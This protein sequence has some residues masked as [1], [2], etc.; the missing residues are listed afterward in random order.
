MCVLISNIDS[1]IIQTTAEKQELREL[2]E[3]NQTQITQLQE[4]IDRLEKLLT[5]RHERIDVLETSIQSLKETVSS[6]KSEKEE[7]QTQHD[8]CSQDVH[9]SFHSFRRSHQSIL[10]HILI[11]FFNAQTRTHGYI[12]RMIR[13]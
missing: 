6:E 10:D 8:E 13:D 7:L 12:T 9:T 11:H 3:K 4:S 1:C 2:D 5:E